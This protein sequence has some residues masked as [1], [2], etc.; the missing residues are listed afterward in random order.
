VSWWPWLCAVV[1]LAAGAGWITFSEGSVL[2][3]LVLVVTAV[4]IVIAPSAA[5]LALGLLVGA[6]VL[7]VVLGVQV[8]PAQAV[9]GAAFYFV[10]RWGT[11]AR[12][13]AAVVVVVLLG[14]LEAV[15]AVYQGSELLEVL[16]SSADVP[17]GAALLMLVAAAAAVLVVP[18]LVGVT[19]QA[20]VSAREDEAARERAEQELAGVRVLALAEADR[21]RLARDVHDTVGHALTVVITQTRVL[22]AVA[23]GDPAMVLEAAATVEQVATLALE[24]VR[25]VLA[26]AVRMEDVT[27]EDLVELAGSTDRVHVSVIGTAA[28][29]RGEVGEAAYRAVQELVTNALRHGDGNAEVQV[30]V[31]T[32]DG[33]LD[34]EVRNRVVPEPLTVRAGVAGTGLSGLGA[35]LEAAGGALT[36]VIV[37]GVWVARATLPFTGRA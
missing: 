23:K 6:A 1:A 12:L 22:A 2:G 20:R 3:L 32:L 11:A 37:D 27:V 29:L 36:T 10:G 15:A 35:R 8:N 21:A 14:V 26:G 19:E 24:D 34:L 13:R 9:A 16:L 31:I 30:S 18:L 5:L 17:A 7:Q 33:R 28:P 25:G 4:A